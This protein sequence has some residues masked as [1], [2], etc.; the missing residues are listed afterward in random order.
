[1]FKLYENSKKHREGVDSRLI[2]ISDRAIQIT[3]VDFGHDRYGGL[4]TS[5]LQNELYRQGKSERDGYRI[6]SYHQTGKALDFYAFVDGKVSYLQPHLAMVALAF[7]QAASELGYKISWGGLWKSKNPVEVNG[8]P[9][10]W[11]CPHIQIED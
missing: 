5:E 2:E 7:F 9:Y 8:I 11:D 3:L 6:K 4:R 1:M 10:G